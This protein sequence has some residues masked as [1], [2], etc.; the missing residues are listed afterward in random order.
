MTLMEMVAK[1]VNSYAALVWFNEELTKINEFVDST[2]KES[3]SVALFLS[4][5]KIK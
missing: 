5:L 4:R 1:Q 2:F 3:R